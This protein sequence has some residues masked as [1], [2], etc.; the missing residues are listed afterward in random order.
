MNMYRTTFDR[1][2]SHRFPTELRDVWH[3]RSPGAPLCDGVDCRVLVQ[4]DPFLVVVRPLHT[5]EAVTLTL[6]PPRPIGAPPPSARQV[7]TPYR[8][9]APRRRHH[10]P[11]MNRRRAGQPVPR[12]SGP[13]ARPVETRRVEISEVVAAIRFPMP[14]LRSGRCRTSPT[15]NRLDD[16]KQ[17]DRRRG[18][19]PALAPGPRRPDRLQPTRSAPRLPAAAS[20]KATAST[21]SSRKSRWATWRT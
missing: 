9:G 8:A 5:G 17:R 21:S 4:A 19:Q 1:R 14:V 12:V 20:I 13:R 11:W 3:A 15:T 2:P 6:A 7:R 18:V 10:P 16:V